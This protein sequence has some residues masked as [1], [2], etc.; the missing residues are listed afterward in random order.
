MRYLLTLTILCLALTS[1]A[2]VSDK[3]LAYFS[4]DEC[5]VKDDSGNGPEG[6]LDGAPECVCG[7]GKQSYRFDD[8]MESMYFIGPL[9]QVFTA[10]DFSVSFYFKPEENQNT[11]ASQV[12]LI[13]QDSC[14]AK[15]GFWVRF[16]G[17]TRV[18]SSGISQN[19]TL[20]TVVQGK[21]DANRCWQYVTLTR[22]NTRYTLY[23]NGTMRDERNSSARINMNNA[24]TLKVNY[25]TC[26]FDIPYL[27]E[28]DELRI[29]SKA[30]SLEEIARNDVQM[31][32]I[33]NGDTL[34]YLGKSFTAVATN[35]CA[36]SFEWSPASNI[37]DPFIGSPLVTPT[38]PAYFS[39]KIN[40]PNCQATDSIFVNVID[41]DTLDC[42]QI[43]IPNAFTP[44]ATPNVNDKF[45]V[46][47]NFVLDEFISFEIF[48]RWGGLVFNAQNPEDFWDGTH[49]GKTLNPGTFLY[50]L[51]YKCNGEE[52][53][54]SGTVVLLK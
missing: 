41:P 28:F 10:S 49:D 1:Q 4:F 9:S 24:A 27:G 53:V 13:K 21:I 6:A 32:R 12:I 26:Q 38:L 23:I 7:I 47:N 33:L 54:K 22:N 50:R 20:R 39:V 37:A 30:L 43:F 52:K 2:Q 34:V 16:N 44:G 31:D 5:K 40:Y 36:T 3:L 45:G 19:D 8:D 14:N 29:H 17:K 35:A 48:D 25:P 46:S 18:L 42:N 11:T 51:R 15:A